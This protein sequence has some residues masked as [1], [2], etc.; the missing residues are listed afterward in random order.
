MRRAGSTAARS[1]RPRRR[2]FPSACAGERHGVG[3]RLRARVHRDLEPVRARRDEELRR[4]R[5]SA[6]ES[7]IAFAGRPAREEAVHAALGQERDERRERLL[8]EPAPA[9]LNGVTAAA[10]AP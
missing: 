1:P 5:R 7:L 4:A 8:V 2:R 6:T 9:V 10:I 3:G